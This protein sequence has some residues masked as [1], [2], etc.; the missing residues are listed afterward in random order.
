[1]RGIY[2]NC[3][4]CE[5]SAS[6]NLASLYSKK[7]VFP[8][9]LGKGAVLYS[10]QEWN[11]PPI[12]E[13]EDNTFI[14]SGWFVF[15]SSKN[16]IEKFANAIL[17]EGVQV[18]NDIEIG[19]F[20]LYWKNQSETKI[21]TDAFGVFPHYIDMKSKK[22]RISPCIQDLFIKDKHTENRIL[23]NVLS[24]KHH[25]F[26]N[27][28]LFDGIQRI[29]PGSV[30]TDAYSEKYYEIPSSLD[31]SINNLG[32]EIDGIR[33]YWQKKECILPLSGGLDSRFILASTEFDSGFTYGPT[34]S[35]EMLITQKY[36]DEFSNYL[37]FD[38]MSEP[39][40]EYEEKILEE[41]AFGLV[42]PI[43][44]LLT[45]YLFVKNKFPESKTFFEGYLGD[46]F[47]RGTFINFKG[48]LGETFKIFPFVYKLFKFDSA[49]L[50]RR[51]YKELNNAEFQ[52]VYSDF[53]SKTELLDLTEYQKITFY[54]FIYGRGG[55]YAVFGSNIL[56][57]QLFTVVSP[58]THK[59]I[60]SKLI[61]QNFC[62]AVSYKTMKSLWSICDDRYRN[63]KVESGYSPNTPRLLI[64][65]IQ[66]IYRLMFH[67]VPSRANYG[68]DLKRKQSIESEK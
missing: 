55:R 39:E 15:R 21:I 3:L 52:M 36:A 35:P 64:P 10:E 37:T 6:Y 40:Y 32:K 26:G 31:I 24:K 51:R 59:T 22:L 42:K 56:A 28:T 49:W 67:I 45:N 41:F 38:Y 19:S 5:E 11:S 43:S 7:Y 60:F 2:I 66:I 48:I 44:R 8:Q 23:S 12:Y 65:F 34:D 4:P 53:L 61:R 16:D 30:T 17:E 68:V 18:V 29:D 14:L 25:L 46:V 20:I 27:Y 58:F 33:K 57:A 9:S 47:Q 62:D 13:Y 50:M 54:E 1:M 63:I